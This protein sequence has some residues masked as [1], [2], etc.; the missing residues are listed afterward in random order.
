MSRGGVALLKSHRAAADTPFVGTAW[1]RPAYLV[2]HMKF[3]WGSSPLRSAG[4]CALFAASAGITPVAQAAAVDVRV[5]DAVGLP[6]SHAVVMLE[7]ATGKLPVAPMTG[8][9]IAQAKRQFTPQIT[10]ITV[11]TQVAFPNFDTVRHHVYSFSSAKHF[12]LKLYAG[13]P[14]APVTFDKPGVA[15]IGC[16]IHDSMV[17]W[18]VVVDT[19]LYA[20]TT[21]TG[22]IHLAAVPSGQYLLKVWHSAMPSGQPPES[23]ALSVAAADVEQDVKLAVPGTEP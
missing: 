22:R 15:V 20:V 12:E 7:P 10:V 11:G 23:S 21:G 2:L 3:S 9:E 17:G 14:A 13:K 16:N 18:V 1:P 19:P 6:L 4:L 5:T 8:V